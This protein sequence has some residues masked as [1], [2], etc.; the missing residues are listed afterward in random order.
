MSEPTG[1]VLMQI[2]THDAEGW[3]TFME[4]GDVCAACSDPVAGRWV[5]VSQCPAAMAD[6]EAYYESLNHV[7]D[8]DAGGNCHCGHN[9]DAARDQ[10]VG[11]YLD[12]TGPHPYGDVPSINNP[13]PTSVGY[14]VALLNESSIHYWDTVIYKLPNNA[15]AVREA[16]H[17]HQGFQVYELRLVTES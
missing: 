6:A 5:P 3:R 1:H 10:A 4:P 14:I 9:S 17:L 11:A 15:I 13:A 7:H 12:G 16:A 8:L 2:G